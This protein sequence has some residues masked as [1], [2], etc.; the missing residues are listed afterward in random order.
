MMIETTPSAIP[1]S[2]LSDP[3]WRDRHEAKL[4]EAH[5]RPVDLLLLGDSITANYELTGPDALHDYRDVE[6]RY[7]A[8]RNALNLG[9]SGDGTQNLLWRITNGEIDGLMP[10]AAVIL[11]GTNDI[12]WL[13][14]SPGAT[15]VGI[16]AVID[17]LRRRL[18]ATNLLLVSI[19]PSDRGEA[20]KKA[21][22]A[23]NSAL[24]ARY[25]AGTIPNVIFRDV[26]RAFIV[27]GTLDVSL[28]A[29]PQQT[30]REPALHPSPDGQARM[31]AALEPTLS[32]LMGD[33]CRC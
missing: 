2:R 17:E 33:R 15:V 9:F 21:T 10:R 22:D 31:A 20:L 8:G 13:G 30:P 5:S 29:D 4:Q 18:P 3:T 28:F 19:L 1:L 6:R 27:G 12:G 16:V 26:S 23:V 11:I 32:R 14:R 25:G 7:F 24:L